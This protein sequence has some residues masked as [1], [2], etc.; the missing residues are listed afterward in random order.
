[1]VSD[2]GQ[3]RP[4]YE[5]AARATPSRSIESDAL[6]VVRTANCCPIFSLL[7]PG[8]EATPY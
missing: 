2:Y 7:A 4:S 5:G 8:P 6:P 3:L 1:M